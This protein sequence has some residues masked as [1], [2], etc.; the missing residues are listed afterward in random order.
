M[1]YVE[2][3]DDVYEWCPELFEIN[4]ET[5]RRNTADALFDA[6]EYFWTVSTDSYYHPE[7]HGARHGLLLH[8][9]RVA[10]VF[11]RLTPSME[12]Q[13]HL[14]E[15]ET[16]CGMAACLLHD[17]FKYGEPPTET[18][19]GTYGANDKLA[20]DYYR[21]HHGE[22]PY[23]VTAAIEAHKGPWGRGSPPT[24]HLQQMVHIADQIAATGFI[25]V[26]V[27]EPNDTLV[28]HFSSLRE[29]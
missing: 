19:S 25:D 13:E 6:P 12:K 21:D 5:L 20:A 2:T 26:G 27:K 1:S 22:L 8:T 24:S 14:T 28:E 16:D 4:D 10:S 29:R 23:D 17:T 9:K 3:T 11:S 18:G 7:E 15:Y